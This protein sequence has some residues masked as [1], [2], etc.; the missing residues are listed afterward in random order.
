MSTFDEDDLKSNLESLLESE[1]AI[2]GDEEEHLSESE[3]YVSEL[4]GFS[5]DENYNISAANGFQDDLHEL[6]HSSTLI[7]DSLTTIPVSHVGYSEVG[8][9]EKAEKYMSS[10]L[11]Q[12]S[13]TIELC[14]VSCSYDSVVDEQ[15]R[16]EIVEVMELILSAVQQ[17]EF[18]R[19][20][21]VFVTDCSKEEPSFL[22]PISISDSPA[23]ENFE[24]W[25]PENLQ[26]S[27]EAQ[28]ANDFSEVEYLIKAHSM[29][30]ANS[31]DTFQKFSEDSDELQREELRLY[32][33]EHERRI[34]WRAEELVRIK[35]SNSAVSIIF[36]K[37]SILDLL[38][39]LNCIQIK[40]QSVARKHIAEIMFLKL[41]AISLRDKLTREL[42]L[43]RSVEATNL[44]LM[45]VEDR[46]SQ[47]L[48][49]IIHERTLCARED[50][51]SASLREHHYNGQK[52]SSFQED[53][54]ITSDL[55]DTVISPENDEEFVE[56]T[57][58]EE[59]RRKE[60][61]FVLSADDMRTRPFEGKFAASLE[62]IG[63]WGGRISHLQ[64][65]N[66]A[67]NSEP[68]LMH[69]SFVD[70]LT[71]KTPIVDIDSIWLSYFE[72]S[73]LL[74]CF[75]LKLNGVQFYSDFSLTTQLFRS[76]MLWRE[77]QTPI[78]QLSISSFM[79]DAP[80]CS[81]EITL[82]LCVE[83]LE[84]IDFLLDSKYHNLT[85]LELNV[86]KI[87]GVSSLRK[88]SCLRHLSLSD[89]DISSLCGISMLKSIERLNIDVNKL[90]NINELSSI[91][92]LVQLKANSNFIASFPILSSP[93]LEKLELYHNRITSLQSQALTR[94]TSLTYLDLGRN[95]LEYI[96]GSDISH[97]PLLRQLV[98]SQNKLKE[99]PKNLRLAQLECLW[100]SG[101]QL[102]SMSSW[103]SCDEN[104]SFFLPLL[105]KLY[106]QD[107]D[108]S[109]LPTSVALCLPRLVE[110]DLSF[111]SISVLKSIQSVH[112]LPRLTILHLQDNPV[113]NY[114][115]ASGVSFVTLMNYVL[116]LNPNVKEISSFPCKEMTYGVCSVSRCRMI[117]TKLN[118]K[119]F[120]APIS[121]YRKLSRDSNLSTNTLESLRTLFQRSRAVANASFQNRLD[122]YAINR[123]LEVMSSSLK[124]ATVN[125]DRFQ[126][127]AN[128]LLRS[129]LLN[130]DGRTNI[131]FVALSKSVARERYQEERIQE[132]ATARFKA[133]VKIQSKIRLYQT[134]TKYKKALLSAKYIDQELDDILEESIDMD[135]FSVEI[136]NNVPQTIQSRKLDTF[137]VPLAYGD[138]IK[139][140][141]PLPLVVSTS[142]EYFEAYLN[143]W[144]AAVDDIPTDEGVS[145]SDNLS[146][147]SSCHETSTP[148][149]MSTPMTAQS[150][151]TENS[152]TAFVKVLDRRRQQLRY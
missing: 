98:L 75:E 139:R 37:L 48:E 24:R 56:T 36:I 134:R 147:G 114:M 47:D 105:E 141:K 43:E 151:S 40:I 150:E 5:G 116:G 50:Y 113:S 101:N 136:E 72:K 124:S 107:N 137:Q 117:C 51:F 130:N 94:L 99:F 35:Q 82:S 63:T 26:Q 129:N 106:L 25:V 29:I 79:C 21:I 15:T 18:V 52:V 87:R 81:P 146:R 20:D 131:T 65:F 118:D 44:Y 138:H 28:Y 60:E 39:V 58:I 76:Y 85:R 4:L 83:G 91:T 86:N 57:S 46:L 22:F 111:N 11:C 55:S 49:T 33:E 16:A 30:S 119:R 27:L 149:A 23:P 19:P 9:N 88:L 41:K 148:S 34:K 152:D 125:K 45:E 95:Q 73:R 92:T 8:T 115:S 53:Y 38:I 2:L 120:G 143:T 64:K 89:N 70:D 108:I 96:S 78:Q 6:L 1:L 104:P 71:Q 132:E 69:E 61:I 122:I 68:L 59:V 31:E 97:C 14:D 135:A 123:Q 140:R 66:V 67:K 74:K 121:N 10:A 12:S 142:Q 128:Q 3:I 42:E 7:I 103:M 84:C 62:P 32:E 109:S 126:I 90:S 80:S 112:L 93:R 13:A 144:G 127:D 77:N 145:A 17:M 54:T 100:L 102:K 110:L 133:A